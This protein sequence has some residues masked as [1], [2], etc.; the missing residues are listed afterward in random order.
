MGF[1][2]FI[3]VKAWVCNLILVLCSVGLCE[4][5]LQF[6]TRINLK[7]AALHMMQ[8]STSYQL[9]P[10]TDDDYWKLRFTKR[11]ERLQWRGNGKLPGGRSEYEPH[12]ELGWAPK[13]S[14]RLTKK[15]RKF[16]TNNL[17][18]RSLREYD[19]IDHSKYVVM[20][21]GDSFTYG[22]DAD[23]NET[24]PAQLQDMDP[25]LEI[26]NLGVGGYGTDQML[27]LIEKYISVFQPDLVIAAICM[28]DVY[29]SLLSFRTFQ[30]PKFELRKGEL[31]L[32]NTPIESVEEV[33]WRLKQEFRPNWF[34][35]V[36][37][38]NLGRNV[39]RQ[40]QNR[41]LNNAIPTYQAINEKIF[42]TMAET[43]QAHQAEF[44]L[45]YV[46]IGQE[47]F[48]PQFSAPIS[49]FLATFAQMQGVQWLNPR[50]AF[51]QHPNLQLTKKSMARL[52]K[53][54]LPQKDLDAL[55]KLEEQSFT[56]VEA[57]FL[58]VAD[59]IG[60]EALK[61]Y[62]PFIWDAA[63]QYAKGHYQ[64]LESQI[65]AEAI[66]QKMLSFLQKSQ[67]ASGK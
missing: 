42:Q 37:L 44:L 56:D 58:A 53:K 57:F 35:H 47:L 52:R 15:G 34:G 7:Q 26:L 23:D 2:F 19:R 49:D 10:V 5:C 41:W 48:D 45:T 17:G 1:K 40:V 46:P 66:Y 50:Q 4:L 51:L 3:E 25:R 24:W 18:F 61:T 20:I 29:R 64:R 6:V 14:N 9:N 55:K 65:F 13:K 12:P 59:Q 30:K 36:R 54:G 43:I 27:L 31:V 16:T 60:S 63:S 28:N 8:E 67:T 22:V 11:Y 33:Y 21:V 38:Y 62:K 39:F 32:T